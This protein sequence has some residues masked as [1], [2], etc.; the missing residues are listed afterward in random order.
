L[1]VCERERDRER[2]RHRYLKKLEEGTVSPGTGVT[3]IS[4]RRCSD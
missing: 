2:E 4:E 1:C 3:G